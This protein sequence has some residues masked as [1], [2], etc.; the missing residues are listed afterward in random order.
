MLLDIQGQYP[1]ETAEQSYALRGR[2]LRRTKHR[3]FP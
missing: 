1:K 3:K 2:R